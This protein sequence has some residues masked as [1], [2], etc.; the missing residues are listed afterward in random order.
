[1]PSGHTDTRDSALLSE[2]AQPVVVADSD[3][4]DA[5]GVWFAEPCL[6]AGSTPSSTVVTNLVED[7]RGG[8][9]QEPAKR[10]HGFAGSAV[11]VTAT[12]SGD[13]GADISSDGTYSKGAGV[14]LNN[15]TW[16]GG[17]VMRTY[18]PQRHVAR[19]RLVL[20]PRQ[21]GAGGG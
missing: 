12:D 9:F 16:S 13:A 20:P 5:I 7:P 4:D 17:S 14:G 11:V 10:D 1:M 18:I 15:I 6:H 19:T 2:A 21:P 8:C 3:G